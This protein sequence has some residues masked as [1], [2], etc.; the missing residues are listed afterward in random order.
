MLVDLIELNKKRLGSYEKL[1][2][3]MDVLPPVISDWK[4]GRRKPTPFHICQ[5]AEIVGYNPLDTLGEVQA[6]IDSENA[7][8]WK[9]WCARRGSNPRPQAS[10][11]CTLSN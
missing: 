9:S 6:E 8:K 11:T 3:K 5:M 10:E 4:A 1:A 2:E 7:D